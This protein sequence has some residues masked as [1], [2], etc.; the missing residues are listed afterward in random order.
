MWTGLSEYVTN[1]EEPLVS[2]YPCLGDLN[3]AEHMQLARHGPA[4]CI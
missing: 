3:V 2:G 4:K 1:L